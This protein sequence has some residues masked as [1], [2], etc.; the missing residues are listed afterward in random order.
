[1]YIYISLIMLKIKLKRIGCKHKPSYKIVVTENL[2]KISRKYNI[3]LGY[4]NPITKKI[5]IN[6]ILLHKFIKIGAYPTNIVR[7]LIY[8]IL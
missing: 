8:K 4:Y 6:L 2:Y 3:E 5:K 7:H 1:L